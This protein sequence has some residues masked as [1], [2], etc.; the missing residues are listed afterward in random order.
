M[1]HM[2]MLGTPRVTRVSDTSIAWSEMGSGPPLV[3]LH[4]LADSHRTWRL[5]APRL[6]SRFRVLMPDLPGHGLSGRP[7][8]PY[9]L[10][11][12]AR[13]LVGWLDAAGVERAHVVGHSFGGGIAQWLVLDARARVERMVL[14][15][16]GGLG[17]EVSLGLRLASMPVLGR[18]LAQPLMGPGTHVMM[19]VAGNGSPEEIARAAWM[20]RAPGTGMAF[21]RTVI[22]CIDLFGQR[23]QT[24]DR[25]GEVDLPPLALVWGDRDPILPVRQG[26][27]ARELLAGASLAR[28]P[29]V[30][31]FPHLEAAERFTG[32]VERFLAEEREPA[33]VRVAF[34][35]PPRRRP[36]RRL[37]TRFVAAMRR[38]LARAHGAPGPRPRALQA[39]SP[40]DEPR[41]SPSA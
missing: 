10:D 30:G 19:R 13:T 28:Y 31:H 18:L 21:H 37:F 3:L 16:P 32:D 34:R 5:A 26:V 41:P 12:Y 2:D 38:V 7:D 23:V 4:G 40:T 8:A 9:T 14:V 35:A 24:W 15:A 29:R 22:G 27:R 1:Y 17:P 39:P 20:N 36:L 25:I 6:A 11:W 33:R